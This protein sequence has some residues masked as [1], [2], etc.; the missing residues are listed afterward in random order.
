MHL[1]CAVAEMTSGFCV[2]PHSSAIQVL[3][4]VEIADAILFISSEELL[5]MS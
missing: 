2:S 1:C 5:G 4:Y 3:H